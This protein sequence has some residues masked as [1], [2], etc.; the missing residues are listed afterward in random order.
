MEN[1][2]NLSVSLLKKHLPEA[3]KIT[4]NNNLLKTTVIGSYPRYP[5]L[6]GDNFKVEWLVSP[7]DNLDKAWK[8]KENLKQ[9]Q[10]EA[11]RWA[12][13]DQETAGIDILSDGEQRRG[14][15]VFYHCQHIGGFDFEHKEEKEIRGKTRTELVPTVREPIRH[16]ENYL[17]NDFNFIKPLTNKE[18]KVTIAGPLTIADS[19]NDFYYND[20]KKLTI[21]IAKAINEEVKALAKAGC[22]AI[23][24]DEPVFIREPKKF[25]DFGINALHECFKGVEGINTTV[26]MCRGYPNKEK[27]VKAEKERYKQVIEALSKSHIDN[28][29]IEDAHDHLDLNV[30]ENFGS[31]G[32]VLG[33]VDIGEEHIETIG[34]IENRVKE[35][36][37]IISPEKL[38]LAPDC[39]LLL[40]KPEIAR[41]KLTNIATAA[42]KIRNTF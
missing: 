35:V 28:I 24:F 22:R 20:E 29:A 42:R 37:Q 15:F 9:L 10:D 25:F 33:V 40:L 38:L 27:D 6:V 8:D 26:H 18:I 16:K 32:T 31:K 30:F 4:S 1:I 17:V 21:D 19:V 7:G 13:K 3:D 34:E 2:R 12:V 14:N 11:T 23:Q 5:K 39:G 36:L 41:A